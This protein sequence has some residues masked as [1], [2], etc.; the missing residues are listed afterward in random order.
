LP[1]GSA[2]RDPSPFTR[3]AVRS[4]QA[5]PPDRLQERVALR[6][7]HGRCAVP[8][9]QSAL[10]QHPL[11]PP[12]TV[13]RT[14]RVGPASPC[15]VCRLAAAR[16]NGVRYRSPI[17]RKRGGRHRQCCFPP[18]GFPPCTPLSGRPPFNARNPAGGKTFLGGNSTAAFT[19]RPRLEAFRGRRPTGAALA[20]SRSA[21]RRPS[22]CRLPL[23]RSTPLRHRPPRGRARWSDS[24]RRRARRTGSAS[25][26]PT[27][28]LPPPCATA[29]QGAG[30]V[31]FAA[32][33]RPSRVVAPAKQGVGAAPPRPPPK[34]RVDRAGRPQR[35]LHS[36]PTLLPTPIVIPACN[37][38]SSPQRPDTGAHTRRSR[39]VIHFAQ[40]SAGYC[41]TRP[42]ISREN[43]SLPRPAAAFHATTTPLT[44]ASCGTS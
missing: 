9:T 40:G 17:Y 42:S 2:G 34:S 10:R 23:R 41:Q 19:A 3:F 25:V 21:R 4:F 22:G 8:A 20:P 14:V 7:R 36:R 18:P 24:A 5:S 28:R 29:P 27:L 38:S 16:G 6:R 33:R 32:A 43:Q 30:H 11:A 12:R 1:F 39:L 15:P 35:G 44:T 26:E 37:R 13:L 31:R